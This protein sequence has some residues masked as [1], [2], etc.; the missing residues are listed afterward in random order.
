M[1]KLNV[2]LTVAV[3]IMVS[4]LAG[5]DASAATSTCTAAATQGLKVTGNYTSD[6]SLIASV[7]KNPSAPAYVLV[8]LK[9]STP[10]CAAVKYEVI[11]VDSA[12]GAVVGL[13]QFRRPSPTPRRQA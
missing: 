7:V 8:R 4:V 12:T 2:A 5:A 11:A 3:V 6:P 10:T 1:R 9:F 13:V